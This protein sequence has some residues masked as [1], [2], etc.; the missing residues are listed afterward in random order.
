MSLLL[1]CTVAKGEGGREGG[2]TTIPVVQ[3][4]SC[5]FRTHT[6]THTHSTPLNAQHNIV[7]VGCVGRSRTHPT[8]CVGGR[9][10]G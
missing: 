4:A 1:E 8:S 2:D 10:S 9:E 3:S 7:E 6:H 5:G